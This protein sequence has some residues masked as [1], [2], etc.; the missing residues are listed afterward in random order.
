[1]N[2]I[3]VI[4]AGGQSTR[5]G[6]GDKCLLTLGGRPMLTEVMDRLRG[7]VSAMILNANGDPTRFGNFGLTTVCDSD[8]GFNGPLSGVLAGMDHAAVHGIQ[9]IVTVAA[10][11]PFLPV[12][13]V[14]RLHRARSKNQKPIAMAATPDGQGGLNLHPTFALWPVAL[15]DDLRA[16]L[17]NGLRKVVAWTDAHG[18]ALE[19]FDILPIDPF[20]NVN[21]PADLVEAEQRYMALK[22]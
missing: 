13:L 17:A 19:E 4:L 16:A 10:D 5:M 8:A 18:C 15:R 3:G 11:T 1:M 12:D 6:G 2:A 20:F 22:R 7:Q 9:Q 14:V 21:T